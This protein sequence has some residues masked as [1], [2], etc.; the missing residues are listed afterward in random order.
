MAV[1]ASNFSISESGVIG[2]LKY[3]IGVMTGD[4]SYATG[5]SSITPAMLGF[6]IGILKMDVDPNSTATRIPVPLVQTSGSVLLKLYA[7]A[8]APLVEVTNAT[9]DSSVTYRFMAVGR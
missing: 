4:A 3:V 2:D 8:A 7:T 6:N 9:N 1:S 5:G